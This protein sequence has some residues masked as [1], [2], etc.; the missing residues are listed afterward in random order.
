M[1][2]FNNLF[3]INL[4]ERIDRKKH[5]TEQIIKNN[6]NDYKFIDAI[7]PTEK[8]LIEWNKNFCNFKNDISYKIG[9]LGCLLSHLKIY[10]YCV[11]NN[12]EYALIMEDDAVF[13][14][15]FN[16]EKI[17]EEVNKYI[18]NEE[19]GI[20]YLGC[21]HR[22]KPKQVN[23]DIYKCVFSHTTHAYLISLKCMKYILDNI[24]NYNREIDTFLA[25]VIQKKFNCYC[26]YPSKICQLNGYSDIQNTIVNYKM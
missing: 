18:N 25:E 1:N 15:D 22:I 21:T 20:F 23:K 9:S 17:N 19:F 8:N 13:K 12:I 11:N 14:N 10:N 6:I 3:I 16:K 4:K 24:N 26:Y 7:R 2:I 5:I